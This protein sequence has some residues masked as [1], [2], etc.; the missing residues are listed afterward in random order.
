MI[1]TILAGF[2]KDVVKSL[3]NLAIN[4]VS[5]VL[6]VRNEI[7]KLKG[8]LEFITTIIMDAE[9]TVVQ[10]AATRNWLKRL[11]EIIYEAENIIDRCRI[12]ADR[13][14]TSQPQVRGNSNLH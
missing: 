3:G 9:Q 10:Q 13:H 4:E 1:E 2:A 11:R 14:Q 5:K 7:N 8:R 12:E 6:C